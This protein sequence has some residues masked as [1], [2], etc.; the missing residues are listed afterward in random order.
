MTAPAA[1]EDAAAASGPLAMDFIRKLTLSVLALMVIVVG[2]LGFYLVTYVQ[3]Q[4][5]LSECYRKAFEEQ[6]SALAITVGAAGRDRRG[7]R[8]LIESI[9]NP[10]LSREQQAA[11]LEEYKRLLAFGEAERATNPV[12]PARTC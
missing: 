4:R 8:E 3:E 2:F 9:T 5:L 11:D 7:L 12:L 10:D 6:S 1:D